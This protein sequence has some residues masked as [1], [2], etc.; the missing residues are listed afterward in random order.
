MTIPYALVDLHGSLWLLQDGSCLYLTPAMFHFLREHFDDRV[1][2]LRFMNHT[3][4]G[5]DWPL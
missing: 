3:E 5:M 4:K 1:I 2:S